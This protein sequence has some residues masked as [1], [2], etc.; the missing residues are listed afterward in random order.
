MFVFTYKFDEDG[1]LTKFKARCVVRGDLQKPFG[2]TYATTL[3]VKS[4]RALMAI[5][6]YF[7]LEAIQYDAPYAFLN[8]SIDRKLYV[9]TPYIFR[10]RDGA[11]LRVL[12][13]LYGLKESSLLWYNELRQALLSL[14]LKAVEG[15]P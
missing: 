4:F 7:G 1:Y 8:A 13:A 12:R 14:G 11:L 2:D 5:I 15:F 9:E 10:R 6:N 3:A